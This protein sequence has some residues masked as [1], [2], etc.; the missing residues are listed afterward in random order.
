MSILD[1]LAQAA[2][3]FEKLPKAKR[4]RVERRAKVE[5]E[6]QEFDNRLRALTS[7]LKK[8]LRL[9]AAR[10]DRGYFIGYEIPANSL[11]RTWLKM[12]SGV[13]PEG[14]VTDRF[15]VALFNRLKRMALRPTYYL[16]QSKSQGYATLWSG[17]VVVIRI[18]W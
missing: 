13:I 5:E 7:G 11:P 14:I 18:N 12:Q 10:G 3:D 4:N 16:T 15:M 8:K 6:E 1:E 17:E 2:D 9:R